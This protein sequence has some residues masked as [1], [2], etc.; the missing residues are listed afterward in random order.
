ME[1]GIFKEAWRRV[2]HKLDA[3]GRID[4]RVA[5]ADSTLALAKNGGS[6][7]GPTLQGKGSNLMLLIDG[8]GLRLAVNI[9]SAS[10]AEVT[11]IEPL[12][13]R[14]VLRKKSIRLISTGQHS[15]PYFWNFR[16]NRSEAPALKATQFQFGVPV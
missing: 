9:H 8:K 3:R 15:T 5:V 7:V 14:H 2:L 11:L 10:P 4:R 16:P 1:L 12:L 6:D 13:D